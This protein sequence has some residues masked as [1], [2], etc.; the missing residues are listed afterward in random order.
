MREAMRR[1]RGARTWTK[2]LFEAPPGKFVQCYSN[3]FW[4]WN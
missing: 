3:A 4:D 1:H 2:A